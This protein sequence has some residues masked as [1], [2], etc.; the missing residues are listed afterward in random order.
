MYCVSQ[1][2]FELMILFC[3]SPEW[4]YR[5]VPLYP[6][7]LLLL[8]VYMCERMCHGTCMKVYLSVAF[9]D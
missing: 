5:C 4:D 7:P 1:V 3:Q 6:M 9:R 8:C 2:V